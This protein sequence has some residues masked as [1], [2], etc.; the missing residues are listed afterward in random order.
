MCLPPRGP[1]YLGHLTL[2]ELR[3]VTRAVTTFRAQLEGR[4]VQHFE[5]NQA[6]VQIINNLT[7]RSP[8]IMSELRELWRVLDLNGISLLTEYINT[9]DNV[10]A[11]ALSRLDDEDDWA[12]NPRI[13]DFLDATEKHSIDR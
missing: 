2:K 5:D 12:L 9:K 4:V 1:S 10:Q 13:F 6:V 3:A 7:T 8:A 11:D